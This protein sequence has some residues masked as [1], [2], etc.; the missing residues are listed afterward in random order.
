MMGNVIEFGRRTLTTM[1][2]DTFSPPKDCKSIGYREFVDLY[3]RGAIMFCKYEGNT[4]NIGNPLIMRKSDIARG[5]PDRAAWHLGDADYLYYILTM[6]SKGQEILRIGGDHFTA[7]YG[8]LYEAEIFEPVLSKARKE[9]P[10]TLR[11]I[12]HP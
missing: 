6:D 8:L 2:S 11:V 1:T 12:T 3:S 5:G 10:T 9:I 7:G 4:M